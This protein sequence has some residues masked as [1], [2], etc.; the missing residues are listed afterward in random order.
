MP[1]DL[2]KRLH[3]QRRQEAVQVAENWRQLRL[4]RKQRPTWVT[5][6]GCWLLCRLGRLLVALGQRLQAYAPPQPA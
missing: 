5:R 1:A 3:D 4:A 2:E 6:Q